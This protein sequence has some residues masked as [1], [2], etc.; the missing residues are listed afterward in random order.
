M[1][2]R[3]EVVSVEGNHRYTREEIVEVTGIQL[4]DN[5]Y[6]WNKFQVAQR[7]L[8]TLPYIGEVSIRRVLPST[9]VVTVSE[10]DAVARVLPYAP[11]E[12]EGEEEGA[13]TEPLSAAQEPWLISVKGKLLESAGAG[14]QA[15]SVT[16]LTILLPQ[17]GEQMAVPQAQ[18]ARLDGLLALLD[19]LEEAGMTQDV[20]QIDLGS[21]QLE[22]RYLDRFTV[23]ME[24]NADFP[25]ELQVLKAVQE[26]QESKHGPQAAGSIDLTQEEY[27]A[28]YD[29][30]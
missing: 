9:V 30:A 10:W 1:F 19:A 18:Q 25:Y 21:T 27:Q 2:F 16:G 8:Q 12:P 24:L 23:K 22:L 3:V 13:E 26:D 5:L 6:A 11:E 4:G 29:P 7:L 15:A 17:A 14:S 28:V 20:S